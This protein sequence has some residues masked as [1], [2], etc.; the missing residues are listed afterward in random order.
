MNKLPSKT[1][2][3]IRLVV[4]AADNATE[5]F[6]VDARFQRIASG[7]GQLTVAVVPGLYKL[8]FRSGQSQMDKLIEVEAGVPELVFE[9][10]P[11]RFATAAPIPDTETSHET[12]QAAAR[13]LSRSSPRISRGSGSGIYLFVRDLLPA[14]PPEPWQGVSLHALD[15]SLLATLSEGTCDNAAGFCS[16][17]LEVDPGTYRLRVDAGIPEVGVYEM[18]L[19]TVPGWQTQLFA[20]I[21]EVTPAGHSVRRPSLPTAAMF[22][23]PQTQGFD[24]FNPRVREVELVRQAL[25]NGRNVVRETDLINLLAEESPDP[26]HIIFGAH[27]LVRHRQVDKTLVPKIIDRLGEP[28]MHHPD[29][30]CL[31]LQRNLVGSRPDLVFE[32]PPM[33]RS[34][35]SL[36]VKGSRRRMGLVPPGTLTD[37]VADALLHTVPWLIH[38]HTE[39]DTDRARPISFS[40]AST[41][42]HRLLTLGQH[43]AEFAARYQQLQ[44]AGQF[45]PLEQNLINATLFQSGLADMLE[46]GSMQRRELPSVSQLLGPIDA[47]NAAIARSVSSLAKKLELF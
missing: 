43:H 15:G 11:L 44:R 32:T 24:P 45:T 42:L 6:V 7:V 27:L 34:S 4:N 36:I 35:W 25:V 3:Q 17:N 47:P 37:R 12:H 38:I 21:E 31:W 14:T 40:K 22:M 8:R 10:H 23:A 46:Q 18:F 30:Q 13:E 1:Q 39:P 26:M 9:G 19:V 20:L 33:L 29:V 16:L 2:D 28:F 41:I 5:I